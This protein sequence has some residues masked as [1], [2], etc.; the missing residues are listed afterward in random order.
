M[1][2]GYC[3]KRY[4]IYLKLF[5]I[6]KGVLVTCELEVLDSSSILNVLGIHTIY[7]FRFREAFQ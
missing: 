1:R 7:Y 6:S 4:S 5:D 2:Y 3:D